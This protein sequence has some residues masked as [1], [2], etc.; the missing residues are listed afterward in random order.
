MRAIVAGLVIGP[1]AFQPAAAPTDTLA[2]TQAQTQL[3]RPIDL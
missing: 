2:S 3:K 1:L